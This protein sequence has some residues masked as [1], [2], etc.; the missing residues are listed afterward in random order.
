MYNQ[1]Q[2]RPIVGFSSGAIFTASVPTVVQFGNDT[3]STVNPII[4]GFEIMDPKVSWDT[5]A[6]TYS[7]G[8]W[9]SDALTT[10]SLPDVTTLILMSGDNIADAVRNINTAT[11]FANSS[12]STNALAYK[13]LVQTAWANTGDLR[14]DSSRHTNAIIKSA[15]VTPNAARVHTA[16]Q[17]FEVGYS[18]TSKVGE[19][20]YMYLE[21]AGYAPLYLAPRAGGILL[22]DFNFGQ[23]SIRVVQEERPGADG[24]RDYSKY[25]G[26]KPVT[27]S[28]VT[29][30]DRSG[31]AAYYSDVLSAWANPRRRP[32]LVYK[33]KSGVE[34]KIALRP[35]NGDSSW[36]VDGVR[37]GFK[38][39][40]MSFSGVDGKDF[41]TTW[42]TVLM[43][44][45]E[46]TQVNTPGTASSSP[47]IRIYGGSTGCLNPTVI[48]QSLEQ[49]EGD[50]AARISLGG[51]NNSSCFIPINQFVEIDMFERTVQLNGLPGPGY[52]Y[53]KYL[54]D[55]Q[56]FD[57]EPYYNTIYL[58]T[59][60]GNGFAAILW[61]DAY[62]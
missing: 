1:D 4:N 42:N 52:S 3:S 55:R 24:V 59:D 15:L 17:L 25:V 29:F 10:R 62:L 44:Q 22:R 14:L 49:E 5:A 47:K 37:A 43:K 54:S 28:F 45:A 53:L 35:E 41:A 8:A 30:E 36:T 9:M 31:S 11:S 19:V 12:T 40:G 13:T 7:K 23:A 26:A 2:D 33:M 56:W 58:E 60:D 21:E 57:L 32:R 6:V 46:M 51:S 20:E 50:S 27:L 39:V 38:E 16:P 34:R 18:S 48:L 61:R